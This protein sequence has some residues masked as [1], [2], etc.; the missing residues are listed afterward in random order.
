MVLHNA[1]CR[2]KL[3]AAYSGI[4]CNRV[5]RIFRSERD[6][7]LPVISP[8]VDM[9]RTMFSRCEVDD[10]TKSIYAQH[11]WHRRTITYLLGYCKGRASWERKHTAILSSRTHRWRLFV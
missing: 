8:N 6:H 10:Y 3:R 1:V 9:R 2:R 11:G 5:G 4:A 7:D